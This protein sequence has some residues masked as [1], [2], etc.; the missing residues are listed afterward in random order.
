MTCQDIEADKEPLKQVLKDEEHYMI[1]T[2]SDSVED[3]GV[4]FEVGSI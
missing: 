2:L 1:S 3:H 4:E